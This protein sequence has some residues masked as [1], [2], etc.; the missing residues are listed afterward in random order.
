MHGQ[1][2]H[3]R[4]G[5][6]HADER[7]QEQVERPRRKRIVLEG[8]PADIKPP[9]VRDFMM[10][11]GGA[12]LHLAEAVTCLAQPRRWRLPRGGDRWL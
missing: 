8:L 1:V 12:P 4:L 7:Q 5:H 11:W 9:E 6:Q 2:E 10:R 3:L